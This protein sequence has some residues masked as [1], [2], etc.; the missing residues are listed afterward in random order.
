MC[1]A[2]TVKL[3]VFSNVCLLRTAPPVG[4]YL[5]LPAF[6]F[7]AEIPRVDTPDLLTQPPHKKTD[8]SLPPFDFP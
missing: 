5:P 6:T 2:F 7:L 1:V 3:L 8:S 4:L